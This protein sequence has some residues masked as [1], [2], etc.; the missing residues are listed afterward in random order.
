M[1]GLDAA[2]EAADFDPTVTAGRI[3]VLAAEIPGLPIDPIDPDAIM[4][5]RGAVVDWAAVQERVGGYQPERYAIALRQILEGL[6]PRRRR[7]L[8]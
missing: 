7:T 4:R 1:T 8:P 2:M 6:A 5:R 3:R